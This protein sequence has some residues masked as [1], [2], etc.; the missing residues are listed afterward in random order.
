[1]IQFESQ[2]RGYF[3]LY[4]KIDNSYNFDLLSRTFFPEE[5]K[6]FKLSN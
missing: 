5:V 1:M 2:N 3:H 4:I 6:R